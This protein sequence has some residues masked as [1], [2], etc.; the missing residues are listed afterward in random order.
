MKLMA[1]FLYNKSAMGRFICHIGPPKTATTAIQS[2][3]QKISGGSVEYLGTFQPRNVNKSKGIYSNLTTLVESQPNRYNIYRNMRKIDHA[4]KS[5]IDLILSEEMLLVS[6]HGAGFEQKL[7]R[8]GQVVNLYPSVIVI[9]LREP[10][11]AL[12]SFYAEIYFRQQVQPRIS[13]EEFWASNQARV[14]DYLYLLETLRKCGF[15]N[16]R[17][18]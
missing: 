9:S 11:T 1:R 12:K 15:D 8:L 13:F 6:Q 17:F 7:Q 16:I 3:L 14:F 2:A 10:V 4:L 5:G 18:F